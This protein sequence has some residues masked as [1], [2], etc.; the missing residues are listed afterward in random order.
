MD[1][2][3]SHAVKVMSKDYIL[4]HSKLPDGI[5]VKRKP[6]AAPETLMMGEAGL[7]TQQDIEGL[8][9]IALG[10]VPPP[11]QQWQV[12]LQLGATWQR[13]EDPG[14]RDLLEFLNADTVASSNIVLKPEPW[15]NNNLGNVQQQGNTEQKKEDTGWKQDPRIQ[16]LVAERVQQLEAEARVDSL[17]GTRKKS[18][19]YNVTD[20][21]NSISYRRW[22]NEGIL[23]GTAK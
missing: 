6:R 11:L 14:Q 8:G 5:T 18:G 1:K 23:V 17:H 21:S 15:V 2:R 9:Q 22:A 12:K 16:A 7:L 13:T 10:T 20:N 3:A 4:K 19:R